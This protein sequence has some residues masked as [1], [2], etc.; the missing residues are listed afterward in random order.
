MMGIIVVSR[1]CVPW[2]LIAWH[3]ECLELRV[4]VS[5][6]VPLAPFFLM[7]REQQTL[8]DMPGSEAITNSRFPT[9]LLVI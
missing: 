9:L 3:F 5:S 2:P 6:E 8:A 4:R 7:S 1:L